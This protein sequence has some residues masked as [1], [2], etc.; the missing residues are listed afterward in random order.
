MTFCMSLVSAVGWFTFVSWAE[1]DLIQICLTD[2]CGFPTDGPSGD[3]TNA[4][5]CSSLGER[6]RRAP[7]ARGARAPP[8]PRLLSH[9][10]G[11][12]GIWAANTAPSRPSPRRRRSRRTPTVGGTPPPRPRKRSTL[13]RTTKIPTWDLKT[14]GD[15]MTLAS[16]PKPTWERL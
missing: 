11:R 4:W 7:T 6:G 5:I 15:P 10:P 9:R 14:P 16:S 8:P 1:R 3:D 13:L 12:R 2:R